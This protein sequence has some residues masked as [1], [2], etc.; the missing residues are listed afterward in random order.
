MHIQARS[1]LESTGQALPGQATFT[2][3]KK[4][5]FNR[6]PPIDKAIDRSW[7]STGRVRARTIEHTYCTLTTRLF[8]IRVD[9]LRKSIRLS[10]KSW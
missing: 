1:V 6:H 8:S 4:E 3:V 2:S 9:R 5:R 10:G 7:R